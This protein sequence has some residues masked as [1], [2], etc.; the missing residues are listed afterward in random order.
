MKAIR[1]KI[2]IQNKIFVFF[3][4]AFPLILQH[5]QHK[6]TQKKIQVNKEKTKEITAK[7]FE[8]AFPSYKV[9]TFKLNINI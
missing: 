1:K 8:A 7:V 6:Y 2:I 5:W 9:S 4:F 3:K